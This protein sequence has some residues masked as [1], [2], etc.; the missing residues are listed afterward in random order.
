MIYFSGIPE[1]N[2][3]T[4]PYKRAAENDETR[5]VIAWAEGQIG[6]GVSNCP[7]GV[8]T[9]KMR[10][11]FWGILKQCSSGLRRWACEFV[12][13]EKGLVPADVRVPLLSASLFF[14]LLCLF[15]CFS[16]SAF[17]RFFRTY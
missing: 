11:P 17:R 7:W 14:L 1:V 3:D 12:G 10:M 2:F 8:Q 15:F 4:S 9:P 16:I 5:R 13:N 6:L